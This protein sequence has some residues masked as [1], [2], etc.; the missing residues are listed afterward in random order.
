MNDLTYVSRRSK[1]IL[2]EKGPIELFHGAVRYLR[3]KYP[4]VE[5]R[6]RNL[7][8]Q[9]IYPGPIADP[10]KIISV[11][12][13]KLNQTSSK[14]ST[15]HH[16]GIIDGSDWDQNTVSVKHHPKYIAVSQHFSENISWEDTGIFEYYKR[17]FDKQGQVD[18][19]YSLNEL[20]KRYIE[21]DEIYQ[22]IRN[23]GFKSPADASDTVLC[24]KEKLDYPAIHI[25]RDGELIFGVGWH[26][27][28]MSRVLDL[29]SIP[30]RVIARHKKW[31]AKRAEFKNEGIPNK[32][33]SHPDLQNL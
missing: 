11:D 27:F 10:F 8:N 33:T 20:K 24:K 28:T 26:R 12:P 5:V 30:V 31:Q 22:D 29:D 25:G 6:I 14:F 16:V 21:I 9:L 23:N 4:F 1:K 32:Y 18:G 3:W 13:D 17:I 19:Y 15:F 2:T 7:Y